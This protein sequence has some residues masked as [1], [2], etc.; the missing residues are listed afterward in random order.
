M[1]QPAKS[2]V[3]YGH[4]LAIAICSQGNL[5]LNICSALH[6]SLLCVKIK[7]DISICNVKHPM[8]PLIHVTMLHRYFIQL[9]GLMTVLE[10]VFVVF[11]YVVYTMKILISLLR[12]IMH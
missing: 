1:Y 2:K 5:I 6:D 12:S 7:S 9:V 4:R 11:M 3:A 8:R 10:M